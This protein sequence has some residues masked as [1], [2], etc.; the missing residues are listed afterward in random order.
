MSDPQACIHKLTPPTLMT[1]FWHFLKLHNLVRKFGVNN[2]L[3]YCCYFKDEIKSHNT[4]YDTN[5]I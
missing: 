1:F 4:K 2:D 5:S 3:L